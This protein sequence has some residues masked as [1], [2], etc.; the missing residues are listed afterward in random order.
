MVS[1][2][3]GP[4]ISVTRRVGGSVSGNLVGVG[5][6]GLTALGNGSHGI[7]L[8]ESSTGIGG[9]GAGNVIAGN[10]GYG[11]ALDGDLDFS[12][13]SHAYV[14]GNAIG[15]AADG[16]PLHPNTLGG[17]LLNDLPG[18]VEDNVVVGN[19]GN[20]ITVLGSDATVELHR[21]VTTDNAALGIDLSGD[22]VTPNDP[23]DG[24]GG[25]NLL[26]NFPVVAAATALGSATQIDVTFDG[27][28]NVSVAVELF[29]SPTCDPSGYGEGATY[30]DEFYL[31][32]DGG[33]RSRRDGHHHPDCAR[34][35]ISSRPRPRT[36][37][38]R[39]TS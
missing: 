37:P 34:R 13:W 20:G 2:N 17:V 4:G 11:I 19:G 6:D 21:N 36:T 33:G 22:G 39:P 3:S 26:Q 14:F 29:S 35:A 30:L 8:S 1:G 16:S 38:V 15:A 12:P 27:L 28:P 9:L 31:N 24:D 5:A 25:P 10:D 7:T 23:G 18:Q 32:T